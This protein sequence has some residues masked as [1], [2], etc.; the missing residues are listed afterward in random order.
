M[1]YGIDD[2][3]C[4][5]MKEKL[6][7]QID[8]IFGD[9][10]NEEQHVGK[11]HK[12]VKVLWSKPMRRNNPLEQP[13]G[14]RPILGQRVTPSWIDEMDEN[15]VF[16]FGSNTRGI[17]D[18]GASFTAVQYF[19]AIVGQPEGPH[20]RSYAIPTD[21]ASLIDIQTSVNSFIVYAKA[22]PQFTFLVTEIGCGTAGYHPM[23]IAPLFKDAVKIQNI[24]LPKIFW[25][26]LKD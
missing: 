24:Y 18:G 26:Y 2:V 25:N 21:G 10:P 15:E 3:N 6:H 1:L 4:N 19:G 22:H 5:M 17:H 8:A 16:V 12:W 7:R 13:K 23:E 20:G 9:E 11:P 14:E